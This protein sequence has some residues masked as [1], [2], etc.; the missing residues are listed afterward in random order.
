MKFRLV[1]DNLEKYDNEG[2]KLSPEQIKFFRNSKIRAKN[3]SLMVCY[4]G[5]DKEFDEFDVSYSWDNFGFHFGTLTAAQERNGKIIKKVY[6]NIKNPFYIDE[7]LQYW[8][9]VGFTEYFLK[10]EDK[11]K[12][13]PIL[14]KE[15]ENIKETWYGDYMD[16][17]PDTSYWDTNFGE[18]FRNAW[19]KSKYDGIKYKNYGEDV[20]SISYMA[21]YPNQIKSIDNKN[22]SSSNNIN[23]GIETKRNKEDVFDV[24]KSEISYYQDYL[25]NKEYA[26]KKHNTISEIVQMSPNEYFKE[27]EKIFPGTTAE[28]QKRGMESKEEQKIID[29]MKDTIL[30]TNQKLPIPFLNYSDIPGQEGR[31]RMAAV[32]ELYGWDEK[33]PVLII[34]WT[35]EQEEESKK[36]KINSLIEKAV[37]KALQYTFTNYDKFKEELDYQVDYVFRDN[38]EKIKEYNIKETNSTFI[39]QTNGIEYLI[40]KDDIKIREESELDDDFDWTDTLDDEEINKLLKEL[41]NGTKWWK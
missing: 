27:L 24:H 38:E 1:E 8:D 35:K 37:N 31:H 15:W 36:E 40:E 16:E 33:F 19:Y 23:E 6:L 26:N 28:K 41:E 3:G 11:V 34:K 13:F 5:T 7:D 30:N 25:D 29:R 22:P 4:H 18:L 2:N 17:D 10:N 21:F 39:L 32:G 14:A 9:A 12:E 20:G